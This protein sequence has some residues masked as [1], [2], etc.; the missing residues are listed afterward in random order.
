MFARVLADNARSTDLVARYGG[1]ELAVILPGTELEYA[2]LVTE[3][4]R[5]QLEAK[6]LAVSESGEQIGRITASF[7]VAELVDGDS[8]DDLVHRADAKLYQ[9]KCAG[10]NRVA[11]D[12]VAAA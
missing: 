5:S 2:L 8:A 7:G 10:R 4:M 3:R 6:Q 12:Q 11:A 1:E 9:A